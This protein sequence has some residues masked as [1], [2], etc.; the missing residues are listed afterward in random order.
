MAMHERK[1]DGEYYGACFRYLASGVL[2][3]A[4][5]GL[6]VGGLSA[7]AFD[8]DGTQKLNGGALAGVGETVAPQSGVYDWD[9][10]DGAG[11]D[12]TDNLDMKGA[13]LSTDNGG[14]LVFD[15]ENANGKGNLVDTGGTPAAI[16]L[17]TARAGATGA[18]IIR[19]VGDIRAGKITAAATG[20]YVPGAITIGRNSAGAKAGNIRVNSLENYTTGG[21]VPNGITI[22]STG[23]VLIQNA[24]GTTIGNILNYYHNGGSSPTIAGVK[25]YHAGDFR[26]NDVDTKRTGSNFGHG[27]PQLFDGGNAGGTFHVNRLRSYR[28]GSTAHSGGNIEIRNYG[29]VIVDG[30]VETWQE[31]SGWYDGRAGNVTIKNIAGSVTVAGRILTYCREST[32]EKYVGKGTYGFIDITGVNGDIKLLGELN[33]VADKA[34]YEPQAKNYM[35]LGTIGSGTIAIGDEANPDKA[36]TLNL[37]L[38]SYVRF[39]SAA[40]KTWIHADID[41]FVAGSP[42]TKLRVLNKDDVVYYAFEVGGLNHDLLTGA[43]GGVYPIQSYRGGVGYLK[44]IPPQ[45]DAARLALS[46]LGADAGAQS[47]PSAV[48]ADEAPPTF[49]RKPSVVRTGHRTKIDF[50]VSRPTDVA[51]SVLDANGLC[52][53]HIVAG[54]LGGENPP[55]EPLKAGLVQSLEWDGKDDYGAVAAGGPFSVRVALGLKPEFGGFLLYHPDMLPPVT[56]LAVGAKGELYCFYLDPASLDQNNGGDKIRVRSREG[57][58]LR[59][60]LPIPAGLYLEQSEPFGVFFDEDGHMVPRVFNW[61]SMALQPHVGGFRKDV[62]SFN[63]VAN[64]KGDLYWIVTGD[65]LACLSLEGGTPYPTFLSKPMTKGSGWRYLALSG[66]EKHIY[67]SA[68]NHALYRIDLETRTASPFIGNPAK[69]GGGKSLLKGP[70]GVA[71]AKGLVY[72]ADSGNG[73]IAIFKEADGAYVSEVK[74]PNPYHVSVDGRTGAIYVIAEPRPLFSELLK[75]DNASA[76]APSQK[77]ELPKDWAKK[78][79]WVMTADTSSTPVRFY[80]A[81]RGHAKGFEGELTAFEDGANGFKQLAVPRPEGLYSLCHKDLTVDQRRNELY[82]KVDRGTTWYRFDA[83]TAQFKDKVTLGG[84][85]GGSS[86]GQLVSDSQGRLVTYAW[87]HKSNRPALSLWTREGKPIPVNTP[88]W[89]GLMNFQQNYMDLSVKDEI[90]VVPGSNGALK[91]TAGGVGNLTVFGMDCLPKRV[92]VSG[93]SIGCIPRLDLKGNIYLAENVRPLEGNY[94]QFFAG[95]LTSAREDEGFPNSDWPYHYMYGSI[96][97]FPPEGGAILAKAPGGNAEGLRPFRYPMGFDMNKRGA[98]KGA[99]WVRFGFAPYSNI[100]IGGGGSQN[101]M[102]EGSGFG[103]DGFGRVFYPNLGRFRVEIID[104]ENNFI[105][106]FGKYGNM[107]SGGSDAIVKTPDIPLAWPTYVAVGDTYAYVSD[108]ASTRVVKV[109]LNYAAEEVCGIESRD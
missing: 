35:R 107:D 58:H 11:T 47:R 50:A 81:A 36:P 44:P 105:G 64:S 42:N 29:K 13:T 98:L 59:T 86:G 51:V 28:T 32:A 1:R 97:K 10:I 63:A 40:G 85:I 99:E 83:D 39:D 61:Q 56:R 23:D 93:V 74:T 30:S 78:G 77:M 9:N 52:V 75:F 92:A 95:K 103:V 73:R 18:I 49:A 15:L 100:S 68:V 53:R 2:R 80:F 17:S 48:P 94:P 27:G 106:M 25:I 7:R 55:P 67:L 46:K 20:N 69:A 19:G 65:R 89:S 6:L 90:Y 72:V 16:S 82:V 21:Q 38:F 108:V 88:G 31:N 3:L 109:K 66:D 62:A 71:A 87:R 101:C 41:G 4:A 22:Y 33:I 102:C 43:P 104:T 79:P 91:W 76:E 14:N 45:T 57:K 60:L 84:D 70:K 24:A 96:V 37:G 12:A 8:A 26:A 34:K 54:V 5:V